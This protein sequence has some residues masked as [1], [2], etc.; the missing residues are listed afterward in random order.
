MRLSFLLIFLATTRHCSK[1]Y[2][3]ILWTNLVYRL[4]QY[5][6]DENLTYIEIAIKNLRKPKGKRKMRKK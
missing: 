2:I 4:L 5:Q 1:L 3:G 6:H